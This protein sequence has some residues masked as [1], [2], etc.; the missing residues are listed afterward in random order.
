MYE[1]RESETMS[2]MVKPRLDP[3]DRASPAAGPEDSC[4]QSWTAAF[5]RMDSNALMSLFCRCWWYTVLGTNRAVGGLS[6]LSEEHASAQQG[7]HPGTV[8]ER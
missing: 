8:A 4:R 1:L 3:Q 7:W 6:N 2:R 5:G